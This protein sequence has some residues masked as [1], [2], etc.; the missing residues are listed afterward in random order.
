MCMCGVIVIPIFNI[1]VCIIIVIIVLTFFAIVHL[2]RKMNVILSKLMLINT[3]I[4][5]SENGTVIKIFLF[6]QIDMF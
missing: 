6:L 3:N 1:F 2:Q 5:N 4:N